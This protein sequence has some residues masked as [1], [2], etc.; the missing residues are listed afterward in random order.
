[1]PIAFLALALGLAVSADKDFAAA[2]ETPPVEI[3]WTVLQGGVLSSN[4]ERRVKAIRALELLPHNRK[5]E[6]WAE[7]ALSDG[8][9]DVRAQAAAV[10][11]SMNA[12]GAKSQLHNALK[13]KEVKVVIAAAG[14]LYEMKDPAAYD[15][16]YALLTG[17]RKS[18]NGLLQSQLD[19][20]HN[21]KEVEK[22]ALQT[23]IGFIPFGGMGW[24]A[25]KTIT[26]DDDSPVRAQAAQRLITD[27][28]P[29]TGRAFAASCS[30]KKWQVRVAVVNAIAKRG[31]PSLLSSVVPL[32][33]DENDT[34]R[35]TS[36]A[37]V[38]YLSG[39]PTIRSGFKGTK[40][41]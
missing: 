17:G 11:G 26:K 30:D 5:A 21:R 38:I 4:A 18:S 20:L 35:Y 3:A 34:V 12:I 40:T 27:P 33:R 2:P 13:D 24:E 1:M 29:A 19:T 31:D 23:G 25:W 16:Y 14:A 6:R 28:D 37:A 10:L 39:R 41:R 9:T 8:N 32:L 22:L 15:I 36:A 7:K